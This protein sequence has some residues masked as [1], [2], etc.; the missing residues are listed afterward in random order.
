VTAGVCGDG[1]VDPGEQCDDGATNG[2]TGD[3]CTSTCQKVTTTVVVCQTLTP[4]PSGTCAVTAGDGGRVIVGTVLT[5]A[6]IYRGGQV[7]ADGQGNILQVGC[8]A[9]CDA[10]PTCAAAASTATAITCPTGVI[11]PGLINAHDH[12]T[13][14]Q[15]QPYT[16][17]GE[18]YEHRHQW[19]QGS[20]GHTKIPAPGGATA[21]QISW[22]ELRFLFGGATSIVGSGGQTG[23]LRNLDKATLEEGLNE[24]AVDFD[25]FP[26]NDSSPPDV[27]NGPVACSAYSGV[28]TPAQ[29]AADH[30]Y[31]PHV[32]EGINAFSENEFVCLSEQ[33]P[34]HDVLVGK[35]A[36]IHAIGLRAADYADMAMNGTAL[37]WSPRS[38]ITLYGDT[39][40]VTEAARMGVRIALGTDWMPTGSINL[41][42]ELKCAD[43]F[44]KTY[45][46]GYFADRDLWMMVTATAAWI[47][48]DEGVIGTLAKGKIADVAVFDGA[49]HPDYRAV[50]DADPQDVVLVMR[51][52]KVLY[53]DAAV[54][55]TI[56]GAG[57]CDALD[58]CGTMKQVCLS[59]EIGKT[60]PALQAAVGG[61]YA[62]YFC[63]A[64][65]SEPSCK[66]TRPA[67]V[68]MSTVYTGDVTASD[69][70]GDGIPDAM[71]NCPTVF[72]PVRPMDSGA[73][74][75]ADGDGK[76]DACDPCPL[77]KTDM[78]P[79]ITT[80]DLDGDGVA[81][82]MDNCP[83]VSNA[84]QKD[85][86]M[87]G[88]GDV[89][90]LCPTIANPGNTPCAATIYQIK[91]GTVH[92]GAQ[93]TL[94]NQLVTGRQAKGYYLQVKPGDPGYAG[95]D[96][97]GVYVF[98]SANTVAAG[99]R[100]TLASATVA[101]Y[102]GQ[103]QLVSPVAMVTASMNEAPPPPV[104]VMPAEVATGGTKAAALESVIVQVSGVTV[105]DVNPAP[106][107]G[108]TPPINEFVVDGSLRVND[109]LYLVT[110][111]P[112]VGQGY[113][114]LSGILDFRNNDSK[115]ELRGPSDVVGGA[116][117][118]AG[119]GPALSYTDVGQMG[120]PTFPTPL[121]VTLTNP[122][123]A[124]TFVAVTSGDPASLTVVGGGAT[125]PAGQMTA[126]VLV[127]GLAQSPSVT[128]TAVLG[129]A[130]LDAAVRVIG[131][132]EQPQIAMLS[133]AS[134]MAA[135]GSTVV[136]TVTLDIPA[137]AGGAIV[138]LM[139]SPANAGTV[140]ATVTVPANQL[141]A[142]FDYVDGS[143]TTM[144]TV[145]A[146]L[147]ASMANA[148]ITL[149]PA[150]SCTVAH[151]LISEIR[152]RGAGGA[153]D[154]FVEL[155]N[156][157]SAPV[158]LDAT[159]KLE[160]RSNAA[161]SYT[162]RWT[163]TGKVVPP[164][165][166]FLVAGTAYTEMPAADE[167]LSTGITD[168]TSI[169]LSQSG[170]VVDAVCYAF[171]AAS[172]A[173]F[174]TDPT[175]TCEGMPATNPHD[176]TTATNTDAS[177][178][179][180]P[181]G[182]LGNCTDTGDNASDLATIMPAAPQSSQSPPTP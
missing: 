137:P 112:T 161:S 113:A 104:M 40:V 48:A 3:P 67:S 16:D 66:P 162:S 30:A 22:G 44:N 129:G 177:I 150:G 74:A 108:D 106:G 123:A 133:P 152:S 55:S 116:P 50:I 34:A 35:S 43:S 136:L 125:V 20:C 91:D 76:G 6:T 84:D 121:T 61:V 36:F 168:A 155:Y 92:V 42:R 166:H 17:T 14:T 49:T 103:I 53:G 23:L 169:R 119:F 160:G 47:T 77:D 110:P 111:F 94:A 165:G 11:S 90:D 131:P 13:Y 81:N 68:N 7:V 182:A 58:V 46:A 39:A 73:Q 115:L 170:T 87:D 89:C 105:T 45:L 75:D 157:T 18:R 37:I 72:N 181:G 144:A 154:E 59:G 126:P 179:R 128:L 4:L 147:G 139:V 163:G 135:P 32:S 134:S 156:P 153:A 122:P 117:G 178:E 173:P 60:Y 25:T 27:C 2:K 96:D 71:D 65:M 107:P 10:D 83:T 78:C 24:T 158:T 79:T 57:A 54:V 93:V 33:D 9:D 51:Q 56:P 172:K 80:D 102:F 145:T 109:F 5:P 149:V 26:L 101:N 69:G 118:L 174:T 12:I 19:R 142:P 1:H 180:L 176:N 99:D 85:T 97:S 148:S 88:I 141:S 38:N 146:T 64:P 41:L 29:I 100:V 143:T 63:G 130:Q 70:D 82:A 114:S 171:D 98:D 28:V 140:P 8:K 151:L 138:S 132:A 124:D 95:A 15:N 62:A 167:A 164:H 175:Y 159:W 52:G 120:T 127:N 21:D 31:L 86:D